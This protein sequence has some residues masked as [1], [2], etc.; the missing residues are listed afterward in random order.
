VH[1][2]LE[3]DFLGVVAKD[4]LMPAAI[5]IH[6]N[7]AVVGEIRG[8]VS[9][10][11]KAGTV[12][13]R[14]GVNTTPQEVGNNKTAPAV[15]RPGIVT[16]P[17]GVA[18]NSQGDI[19]VAEY[20]TFGRVHRFN[21]TAGSASGDGWQP[22]FN[23]KDLTGW[24]VH[25]RGGQKNSDPTGIFTVTNGMVRTYASAEQGS[26]QP[27]AVICTEKDFADYD[28]RFEYMW[29]VKRYAPRADKIRDAGLLYHC[30]D[31][32]VWPSSVECQI[33]EGDTG[34]VPGKDNHR[35]E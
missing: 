31:E 18:F 8:E 26:K 32:D 22:I 14:L 13:T 28:L 4:L 3:G 6:G 27:V 10:L 11:D 21:R 29:G 23:G 25:V 2:S 30:Y 12:V 15:W 7:Y 24:Y 19:F 35:S 33:Q 17:H 34:S 5:A 1:L 16:A 20:S 9:I